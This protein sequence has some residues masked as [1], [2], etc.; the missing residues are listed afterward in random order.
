[1]DKKKIA[2]IGVGGAGNKML[3]T[4][5]G[6]DGRYVPVFCNT[7]IRE[8]EDL[9]FFNA[10]R[11][12]L[13]LSNAEGTGRDREKAQEV[14]KQ[15]Q[16]RVIDFFASK[17]AP[18]SGI[19]TFIILS[20]ADGGTGS[21]STPLLA[22]CIKRI[23]PDAK[24]N[25]VIAMPSKKEK[26]LS[27]RNTMGLWNE[28]IQLKNKKIIDAIQFIDNNKMENEVEFNE[29]TMKELDDSIAINYNE[30]DAVDSEK[31]NT[32]RGYKVVLRLDPSISDMK[33]AIDMAIRKSNFIMPE[34]D[35]D[36]DYLMASFD[37][38]HYIKEECKNM[39]DV[40][41]LDKYDYNDEGKNMIVL[42]GVKIPK[43]YIGTIEEALK[44][45][46][47]KKRERQDD[48][49]YIVDLDDN[50]TSK[51]TTKKKITRKDL[52]KLLNNDNFWD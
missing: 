5:M 40:F 14:I 49:D 52:N 29:A 26:E 22:K 30:I 9:N 42:G 46:K 11:N 19:S 27:L 47:R 48:E 24:V 7:N 32:A 38:E 31:V 13:Y 8:M 28:I 41:E 39:F 12:S 23:N 43:E 35:F 45:L 18:T 25:V 10:D 21:G 2:V 4:L 34:D 20:S 1:M 16:D 36:C 33:K 15:D 6:I 51:P 17:F 3:D 50:K 44:D 37:E